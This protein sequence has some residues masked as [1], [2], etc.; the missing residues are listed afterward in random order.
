MLQ[1]FRNPNFSFSLFQNFNTGIVYPSPLMRLQTAMLYM[2]GSVFID[3][4]SFDMGL[5]VQVQQRQ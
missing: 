1:D 2:Y 3:L 4:A 5:E